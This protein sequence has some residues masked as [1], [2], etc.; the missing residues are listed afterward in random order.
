MRLIATD[1][2]M[3]ITCGGPRHGKNSAAGGARR[4][5]SSAVGGIRTESWLH[6]TVRLPG[7]RRVFRAHAPP[8]CACEN[9]TCALKLLADF[10]IRRSSTDCRS[11]AGLKISNELWRF[12]EV[13]NREGSED[14]RPG[15]DLGGNQGGPAQDQHGHFVKVKKKRCAP[16]STP[17]TACGRGLARS[18]SSPSRE[19]E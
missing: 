9:L 6:G 14:R 11:R 7:R 15:E 17:P 8:Q 19:R 3:K 5:T 1:I 12:I 13:D 2:H 4:A 10:Q 16:S 18:L